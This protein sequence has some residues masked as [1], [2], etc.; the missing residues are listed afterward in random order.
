MPH[1]STTQRPFK[2]VDEGLRSDSTCCALPDHRDNGNLPWVYR[3]T[4][5][6]G[7]QSGW[8]TEG[9][10]GVLQQSKDK[11]HQSQPKTHEAP[12]SSWT[13]MRSAAA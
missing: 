13:T 9:T 3:R 10:D 2:H 8:Y 1:R 7:M 6:K 4:D 11:E 12:K 5:S